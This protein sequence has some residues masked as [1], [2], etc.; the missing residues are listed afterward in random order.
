M[1]VRIDRDLA[2]A[3][4][5]TSGSCRVSVR[6]AVRQ[7]VLEAALRNAAAAVEAET[8]TAGVRWKHVEAWVGELV[9]DVGAGNGRAAAVVDAIVAGLSQGG[10]QDADLLAVGADPAAAAAAEPMPQGMGRS[11]VLNGLAEAVASA[12]DRAGEPVGARRAREAAAGAP[13]GDA[14]LE[15][16]RRRAVLSLVLRQWLPDELSAAGATAE[17]AALRALPDPSTDAT[18]VLDAVGQ[19]VLAAVDRLEATPR[20][21]ILDLESAYAVGR[22]LHDVTWGCAGEQS[23]AGEALVEAARSRRPSDP[24]QVLWTAAT[25]GSFSRLLPLVE[26]L[27]PDALE[28]WRRLSQEERTQ[29]NL[30][31]RCWE[32]PAR[33]TGWRPST[34][35]CVVPSPQPGPPPLR[36]LKPPSTGCR[37][38]PGPWP[39]AQPGRRRA[40]AAVTSSLARAPRAAQR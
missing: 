34:K 26:A 25:T 40:S 19:G 31:V 9:V 2:A 18:A 28:R 22:D 10:V 5:R 36:P 32:R 11:R 8:G 1:P 13:G 15:D 4:E 7:P 23:R 35:P 21:A 3:L 16:Q 14:A 37:R 27:G 30:V 39:S 12:Y 29:H 33:P 17:A 24:G 20:A 6:A 38:W